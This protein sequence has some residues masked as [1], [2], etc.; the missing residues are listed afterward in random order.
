MS[1][2]S[3]SPTRTYVAMCFGANFVGIYFKKFVLPK[4]IANDADHASWYFLN[5]LDFQACVVGCI[6]FEDYSNISDVEL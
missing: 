3:V 6:S 2:K 4:D 5:T 1:F